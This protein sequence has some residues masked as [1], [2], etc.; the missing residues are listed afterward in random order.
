MEELTELEMEWM[1]RERKD[2]E[3]MEQVKGEGFEVRRVGGRLVMVWGRDW[4][5]MGEGRWTK[6]EVAYWE[7]RRGVRWSEMGVKNGLVLAKSYARRAG[8]EWPVRVGA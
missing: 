8:K 6:G 1:T 5:E 2:R 7:R 3:W 4:S